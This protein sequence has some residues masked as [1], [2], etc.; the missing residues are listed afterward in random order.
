ME[1]RFDQCVYDNPVSMDTMA[2]RTW[3]DDAL[4]KERCPTKSESVIGSIYE[5]NPIRLL[6]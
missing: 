1:S 2:A 6:E 4:G 3:I 5:S